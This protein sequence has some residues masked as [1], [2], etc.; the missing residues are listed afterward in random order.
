MAVS[1]VR[2]DMREWTN[3]VTEIQL[4]ISSCC[5]LGT[6]SVCLSTFGVCEC[7]CLSSQV[8]VA[9]LVG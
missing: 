2:A 5:L 4:W 1:S 9:D 7:T 6:S 8:L 3:F